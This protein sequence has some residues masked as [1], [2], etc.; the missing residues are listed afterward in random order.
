MGNYNIHC[1]CSFCSL[2][3][4]PLPS[5]VTQCN[6]IFELGLNGNI[7]YS[8]EISALSRYEYSTVA[9]YNCSLGYEPTASGVRTCL[10]GNDG[11]VTGRW[12][13]SEVTC[14]GESQLNY[15]NPR[16]Y[17]SLR[18]NMFVS[19]SCCTISNSVTFLDCRLYT[20]TSNSGNKLHVHLCTCIVFMYSLTI[21]L[22]HK[23]SSKF[24]NFYLL[25]K[26]NILSQGHH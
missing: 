14:E 22:L 25:F 13:N 12:S 7:I 18:S 1:P 5:A 23:A 15:S 24:R 6:L 26:G 11:T 21:M 9:T 2:K 10:D 3:I 17:T 4:S 20:Y 19:Q 16:P 8:T